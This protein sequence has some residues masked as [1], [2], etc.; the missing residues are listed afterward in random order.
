MIVSHEH[1]FV[2]L[3]TRKTAG[4]S[5]EIALSRVCGP[6]DIITPISEPD[7]VKRR[8]LGGRPPQ[9]H[10]SPPLPRNA[11]NHMRAPAVKQII[12][13]E[14]WSSYFKFAVQRNPW[15]AVVSLYFWRYR[16]ERGDTPPPFPEFVRTEVVDK[17]ANEALTYRIGG[18]IAVDR[19]LRYEHLDTEL[20]EVW[21]RLELP[22]SPDLP[23]V[24]AHSRPAEASYRSMYDDG[25]REHVRAVFA[26]VIDDLRYEF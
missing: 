7:E 25:S 17:L 22:G 3:K 1:R 16:A 20:G 24:K 11:F 14:R 15:D 5:I 13:A 21:Q 4:T 19:L 23:R 18:R 8:E 2:F 12:G 9:Q 10:T 6:D 26:T